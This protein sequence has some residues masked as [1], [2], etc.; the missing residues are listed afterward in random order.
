[1]LPNLAKGTYRLQQLA[2]TLLIYCPQVVDS[3]ILHFKRNTLFFFCILIMLSC[4]M[5]TPQA[6]ALVYFKLEKST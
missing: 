4:C 3:Y 2:V 5:C 6:C 1:M